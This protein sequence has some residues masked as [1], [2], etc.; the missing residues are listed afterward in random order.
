MRAEAAA[1]DEEVPWLPQLGPGAPEGWRL[2]AGSCAV[3]FQSVWE[4]TACAGLIHGPGHLHWLTQGLPAHFQVDRAA[5][6]VAS[7]LFL[8]MEGPYTH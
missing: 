2:T 7:G 1:G 5:C 6:A 8:Q 4:N 3:L